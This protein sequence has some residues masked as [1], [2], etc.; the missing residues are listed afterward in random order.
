MLKFPINQAG[1][2]LSKAALGVQAM[3]RI[4]QFM[5]RDTKELSVKTDSLSNGHDH[6]VLEVKDGTFFVG[7]SEPNKSELHSS[8]YEGLSS[9]SPA[10]FTLS[11]INVSVARGE[12]LAV[13]GS[14]ASGKSTLIEGLLGDIRSSDNTNISMKG[15]VSLAAQTPF[16]LSTTVRENILFGSDYNKE[17]YDKVLDAC[18]LRADLLQW[19]AGDLTEIGER[20]VTMSGGQKARV[21]VARAVYANSDVVLFDDVLSA[22]DA[23]TSQRL[24]DNVF[25]NVGDDNSLLHNSGIVLVTHAVHILRRVNKI[26]L[27][28]RG[29]CIFYGTY[30]ELQT[31]EPDNSVH[32]AKIKSMRLHLTDDDKDSEKSGATGSMR[33]PAFADNA[34]VSKGELMSAEEREHGGSALSIWFLWFKYAGG[35]LFVT[36]QIVLM[37]C[38]RGAYVL[39]DL[40]LAIWTSS[41]GQEVMVFGV[42]FPN[43]YDGRSAQIPYL[44]VYTILVAVMLAFLCA[45]SQWAVHGGLKTCERVFSTMT[46]RVLHAPM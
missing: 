1:Q 34:D 28:D 22:L 5:G 21:S 45:R 8:D 2:L 4:S 37:A 11:N 12:V 16:I 7:G 41:A 26:L 46:K 27:L 33:S 35:L 36:V 31:F 25:A 13:V 42:E 39:I 43:Q 10:T 44:I 30:E 9:D 24:F 6:S 14:V 32:L 3:H 15:S 18:C 40:W 38:D 19:P 29:D 17:R 20:G 23:G